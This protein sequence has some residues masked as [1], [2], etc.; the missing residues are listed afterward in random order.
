MPPTAVD[1]RKRQRLMSVLAR[2]PRAAI[3]DALAAFGQLPAHRDMRKAETGLVTLRG[4]I[5]GGG[6]AFNLGEATVTRASVRLETGEVG[7]A[8]ALGR[9][10]IKARLCAL[11]DAA[12]QHPSLNA[13]VVGTILDPLARA[14]ADATRRKTEETTAT[15][16]DFFTMVRGED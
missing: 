13:R 10:A 2:M 7:H 14:E 12:F 3:D 15:K 1:Q 5:G 8:Y 9:D 16:V 6:D 4:R 11:I